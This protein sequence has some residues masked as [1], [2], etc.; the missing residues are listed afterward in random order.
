MSYYHG[1]K[2]STNGLLIFLDAANPKCYPGSG[3]TLNNLVNDG[4]T[5][6]F[7]TAS[8]ISTTWSNNEL[9]FDGSND[10]VRFALKST[11]FFP[12]VTSSITLEAWVKTPSMGPA[13]TVGGIWAL[14]YGGNVYINP[15][16]SITTYFT[17]MGFPAS[18]YGYCF[19]TGINIFSGAWRH[20]CL[21]NNGFK[22]TL[23]IDGRF[24]NS[25]DVF[26]SGM[27]LYDNDFL[28]GR[29]L[30]DAPYYYSGSISIARV[31]NRALTP[32]EVAENYNASKN[33]FGL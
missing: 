33:R 15:D 18:G 32:N 8:M 6:S 20:I 13:Q 31:Y 22:S 25:A 5:S 3:T 9:K 17:N 28:L 12:Y 26:W 29:N 30:N 2:I 10:T 7:A 19:S 16:G 4:Y 24:N 23:F 27:M 14:S 1:P 11:E 21:T